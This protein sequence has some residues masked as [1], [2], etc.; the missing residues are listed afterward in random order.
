MITRLLAFA[1]GLA[2][3]A[4][5]VPELASS[6]LG[7]TEETAA[8]PRTSTAASATASYASSK[9]VVL[10][11]GRSGH[12][13]GTFRINGRSETGLVDTGASVIAINSSAARRFGITVGSL[14]FNARAQTANGVVEAAHV[15]LD[16]V[17]IGGI[18]LKDVEAMVLPDKALSGTLVG[19]SFL[20]RLSS[21]RVENGAL[22][23]IK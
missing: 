7:R 17:E 8:A 14:S 5:I 2:A 21:Y 11:A 3:L 6:Y 15:R 12:F 16:R 20:G 10:E 13:V 18:S 1:G 9:G 22:H 19:M 23:L 4:L